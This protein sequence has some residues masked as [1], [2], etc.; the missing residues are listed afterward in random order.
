M[1]IDNRMFCDSNVDLC[2][3]DDMLNMLGGNVANFLF[4]GYFSGSDASLEPYCIC[5]VDKFRKFL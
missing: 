2:Y 4:L 5:L 1:P 3:E